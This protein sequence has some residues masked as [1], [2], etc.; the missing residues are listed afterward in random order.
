MI[1]GKLM[2]VTFLYL[3]KLLLECDNYE[4]MPQN[5]YLSKKWVFISCHI[6]LIL[7]YN[8]AHKLKILIVEPFYTGSHKAWAEG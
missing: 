1:F 2:I 3:L 5:S 8:H 4:I 6:L 7:S